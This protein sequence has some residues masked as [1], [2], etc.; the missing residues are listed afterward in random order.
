[1]GRALQFVKLV[2]VIALTAI[3]NGVSAQ[4]AVGFYDNQ[5]PNAES[6][7][8]GMVQTR[9][10]QDNSI[11]PALLRLFFHDCFAVPHSSHNLHEY[12]KSWLYSRKC[13]FGIIST[14]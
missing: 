3:V 14:N 4:T 6:I 8:Q 12:C 5:C 13:R 10:N 1:M 9:F 7:I 11:A 2:A